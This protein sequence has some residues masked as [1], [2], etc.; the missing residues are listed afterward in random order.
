MTGAGREDF[1]V[2]MLGTGRP[3]VLEIVNARAAIPPHSTFD[4]MQVE[5]QQVKLPLSPAV[6]VL[7]INLLMCSLVSNFYPKPCSAALAYGVLCLQNRHLQA[8]LLT[9]PFWL[10]SS[11]V[12]MRK[13]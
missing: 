8:N 7:C 6:A 13:R 9:E 2:R 1:D 5:L 10:Y 4:A 3:F 11:V 12:S